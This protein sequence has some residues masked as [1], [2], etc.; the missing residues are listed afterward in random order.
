MVHERKDA[1]NAH[2]ALMLLKSWKR[3]SCN[4]EIADTYYGIAC[5]YSLQGKK[6][7][8]LQFLE[9]SLQKGFKDLHQ[10]ERNSDMNILRSDSGWK[11]LM[12]RYS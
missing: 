7:L 5:I 2:H 3:T 8:A 9:K 4:D 12:G 1:M 6:R 10:I 11:K